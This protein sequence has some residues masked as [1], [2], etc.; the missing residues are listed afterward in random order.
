MRSFYVLVSYISSLFPNQSL[1]TV[2]KELSI[3]I[4]GAVYTQNFN[5]LNNLLHE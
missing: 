5:M 4:S 1:F 3:V 2:S